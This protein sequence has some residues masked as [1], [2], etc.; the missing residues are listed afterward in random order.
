MLP[1][2]VSSPLIGVFDSGVGGL[3]VLRALHAA[4]PQAAWRYLADSANAPYGGRSE[5]FVTDR[6]LRVAEHLFEQGCAGLVV[7]CNTA[8]AIAIERLRERWPTR[9]II[10]VEPGV[11][12]A[13]AATRNGRVGV[14]A[15]PALLASRRYRALVREQAAAVTIVD[16]SCPELA[17]LIERA[18]AR[19]PANDAALGASVQSHCDALRDAGV[20]TVVLGCTHYA[21]VFDA[22]SRAM[23]PQVQIV[24]TT[25]AVAQQAARRFAALPP[26]PGRHTG[27]IRLTA[28]GDAQPLR[29]TATAWLGADFSVSVADYV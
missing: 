6:S 16:R 20:D 18:D 4:L 9:P 26:A 22:I 28:T 8:T 7:A 17:G 19:N 2:P 21:F 10:G 11:K 3:S 29:D 27:A 14:L 23:G 5:A 12:P 15:T 24:D 13:V 1:D 25:D